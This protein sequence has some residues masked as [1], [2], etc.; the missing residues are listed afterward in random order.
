MNVEEWRARA[1]QN[2][3]AAQHPAADAKPAFKLDFHLATWAALIFILPCLGYLFISP[4]V[5]ARMHLMR[6]N[7]GKAMRLYE[8]LVARKPRQ[9]D[10]YGKLAQAYL[11]LGRRD[12]FA[13]KVYQIV[14]QLNLLNP[15]LRRE[16]NNIVAQYYLAEGRNDREAIEVLEE[17][18]AYELHQQQSNGMALIKAGPNGL[19]VKNAF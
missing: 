13:L 1:Y 10:Y 19:A 18:L 9:V 6:G 5:H 16:I 17:A 2:L 3:H 11:Q 15:A 4:A 12:P 8:E 14:L 7:L